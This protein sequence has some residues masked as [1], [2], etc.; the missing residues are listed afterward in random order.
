M[1]ITPY[2]FIWNL[3][4]IIFL[5]YQHKKFLRLAE[6]HFISLLLKYR[7]VTLL[8]TK[9]KHL[10]SNLFIKYLWQFLILETEIYIL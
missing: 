8:T 9:K 4:V 6:D 7:T 5:F 1:V 3:K 2:K 10:K